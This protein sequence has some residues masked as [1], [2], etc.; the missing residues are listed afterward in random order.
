M[1]LSA[2]ISLKSYRHDG[3]LSGD[4]DLG[5]LDVGGHEHSALDSD[6]GLVLKHFLQLDSH[7]IQF[8]PLQTMLK[9]SSKNAVLD[10]LIFGKE[11]VVMAYLTERYGLLVVGLAKENYQHRM[12][13]FQK[14]FFD[15][16][17]KL[18]VVCDGAN[19]PALVANNKE[20]LTSGVFFK[21]PHFFLTRA[22]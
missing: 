19:P 18:K 16:N 17:V 13:F 8:E 12:E 11:D 15:P 10:P 3:M 1:H 6:V 21:S 7:R 22:A 14:A 9:K 20:I 2:E 4:V 5:T